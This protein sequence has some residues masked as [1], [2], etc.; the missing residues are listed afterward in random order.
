MTSVFFAGGLAGLSKSVALMFAMFS[1]FLFC[2]WD[3]GGAGV[4]RLAMARRTFR[5]E[6]DLDSSGRG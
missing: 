3:F 2:R 4:V 1:G 6:C 5:A